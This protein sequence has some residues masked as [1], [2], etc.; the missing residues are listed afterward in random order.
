MRWTGSY[1]KYLKLKAVSL[2]LGFMYTSG[3]HKR[4]KM[5]ILASVALSLYSSGSQTL[6]DIKNHLRDL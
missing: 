3:I 6:E 2:L 5:F 4:L 1:G